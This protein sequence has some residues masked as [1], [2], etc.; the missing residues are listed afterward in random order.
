[1][2]A[3]ALV[4]NGARVYISSRN[5]TGDCDEAASVLNAM[6]P[7]S[8]LSLPADLSSDADCIDLAKRLG[9]KEPK[10]HALWVSVVSHCNVRSA[11][12]KCAHHVPHIV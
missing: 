9:E 5:R 12:G 7:G 10:L 6:G 8:C 11:L 2:I 1:M 3:K 4:A